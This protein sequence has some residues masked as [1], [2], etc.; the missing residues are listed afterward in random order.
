MAD[1]VFNISKGRF[2]EFWNRVND[3]DPAA[4]VVNLKLLKVSEADAT[5]LDYDTWA[6]IVAGSNTIADFTNY[7]TIAL[8]DTDLAGAVTDDT[9]DWVYVDVADQTWSSAGNGS[10]NT[11]TDMITCYDYLGTDAG[12]TNVPMFCHD[13]VITTNGSDLTAQFNAGGLARAA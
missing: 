10:N 1:F 4:S 6:A 12:A 9:N 8:D 2:A 7:A 5:L 11:L 3:N 13:F